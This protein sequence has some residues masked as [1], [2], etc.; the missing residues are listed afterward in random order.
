MT[1]TAP[2]VPRTSSARVRALLTRAS[3]PASEVGSREAWLLLAAIVA[4]LAVRVVY[5]ILFRHAALA[6]DE[7]EYDAEGQFIAHGHFFWTTV[8][9]GIAHAGAWKAPGY[10]L[11]VGLWYALVGHHPEAVRAAQVPLGAVTILLSWIL[12][13]RLFG[14]RVAIVAAFAVALYP[15]AWQY[16]ELL[17]S[18][19]L[20][21]PLTLGLLILIFS[22]PPTWRRAIAVGLL[23]G[24]T[25]FVRPTTEFVLAGALVA[26]ILEAGWRRGVGMT[27]AALL[28]AVCVIVPWTVRNAV[29]LHGFVPISLQDA[30]AYGTFNPQSASN[31]FGPWAWQPDPASDAYL[32]NPRHPL[33]DVTLRAQLIHR[34]TAYVE[35]HPSSLLDAFFWNGLSRLWDIRRRSR[36]VAEVPFEGRSRLVTDL[37]LDVYDVFLPLALI[38]LWRVRRRRWLVLG[39]LAIA[40][41]AS[42][43]YT[44]DSGT[45]YRAPLEPLIAI[46]ACVGVL[47]SQTPP[48]APDADRNRPSGSI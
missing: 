38:G 10:P 24:L 37:G 34:A 31:P 23:L 16:E 30:A 5:V 22:R 33:S 27:V 2:G 14:A 8:P 47:G 21:T 9:Y 42:V 3:S 6:G 7:V 29:V 20:A 13:R 41:A 48:R 17:Y 40:L 32:F 15:L 45:R 25:M 44:I 46:L 26:W 18:E 39:F 1:A 36:S 12:A 4:G 19:S 28:V 35:A 11:W 43:V